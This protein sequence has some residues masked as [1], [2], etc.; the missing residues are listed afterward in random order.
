LPRFVR[1][2]CPRN[3]R[4]CAVPRD[5]PQIPHT[6]PVLCYFSHKMAAP[7]ERHSEHHYTPSAGF[8]NSFTQAERLQDRRQWLI[9]AGY[10]A[11]TGTQWPAPTVLQHPNEKSKLNF[12]LPLHKNSAISTLI[13]NAERDLS[14]QSTE[15][16]P[17]CHDH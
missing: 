6:P 16:S 1:S 5:R 17:E 11:N 14:C 10:P 3:Y 13:L 8:S 7:R 15:I 4:R 9:Q 12:T 2:H